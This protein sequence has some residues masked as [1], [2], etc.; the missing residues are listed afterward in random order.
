MSLFLI[1]GQKRVAG[2]DQMA[3]SSLPSPID[4]SPD[5]CESLALASFKSGVKL[6]DSHSV[7][8]SIRE[9]IASDIGQDNDAQIATSHLI[10]TSSCYGFVS[11]LRC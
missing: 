11:W 2:K 3:L 5:H 9:R 4:K 10:L 7:K 8:G 1:D 6:S